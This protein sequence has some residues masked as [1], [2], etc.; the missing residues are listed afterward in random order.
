MIRKAVGAIVYQGTEILLVYK[1]KRSLLKDEDQHYLGK[2]DF[3]KGGVENGDQT[4]ENSILRELKEETGS[5]QYEVINQL[6]EKI[7]F[8]FN[9]DFTNKT[10]FTEQETTMFLVKYVGDRSDLVP[11]DNE[12]KEIKFV[13]VD[14][15]GDI[16]THEETKKLFEC[17][18]LKQFKHN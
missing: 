12:I 4:I 3:P 6:D 18:V 9:K 16:L 11:N 13:P 15:A 14:E 7:R 2:W 1:V 17:Q 10:G 5:T 8:S